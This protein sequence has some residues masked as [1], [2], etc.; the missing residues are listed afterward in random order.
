MIVVPFARPTSVT[1]GTSPPSIRIRVPTSSASVFVVIS[2]FATEVMLDRASP[3]NP[4]VAIL[5]RSS[6]PEILL[7][8][9]RSKASVASCRDMPL[10]LSITRI[11]FFPPALISMLIR[12][13][14]ASMAFSTSSLTTE[15][16]RSTTSPAAILF[17]RV[18]GKTF[19]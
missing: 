6:S 13:L 4:N 2:T 14:P 3:R 9:C 15:A 16:G 5:A 18:S 11:S 1:R 17:A 10:P 19:I 7:V 12:T 8:A